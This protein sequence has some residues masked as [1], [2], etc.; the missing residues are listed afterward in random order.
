MRAAPHHASAP[1]AALA[2]AA[3][4]IALV[5]CASPAGAPTA[6]ELTS[7]AATAAT[8]ATPPPAPTKS[9]FPTFTPTPALTAGSQIVVGGELRARSAPN[10]QAPVVR[11]LPDL[12]P[13]QIDTAVQGENVVVGG[14]RWLSSYP[15][16]GPT[17]FRLTD[18]TFVYSAFIFMLQPGEASP[19]LDPQGKEKWVDV[20]VSTQR[21]TAMVGDTP[22]YTALVSTGSP[23]FPT[24]LGSHKVEPDGRLA[25]ERMT[26]S[27]AG[28]AP[29]QAS[30]D[31]QNVF[32][33]QYFD[34][35][36]DALHLNYWR[37]VEVFGRTATSHGCVGLLLH[38]AQWFWL[39]GYPGMRVEVHT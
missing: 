26:A 33:T 25:V 38:D 17:W 7:A 19:L 36:G 34:R 5:A 6:D 22:V 28:Y 8:T 4:A 31:V 21:A 1:L 15:S 35:K 23:D 16:W 29:G 10:T 24:P 39:F 11:T 2:A 32:F 13:V 37:P 18:G 30:Y 3:S 27:Q 12:A 14:Q 20:N 9:P